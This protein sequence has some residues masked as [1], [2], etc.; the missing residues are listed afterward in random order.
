MGQQQADQGPQDLCDSRQ[1]EIFGLGISARG[2]RQGR[3]R[4]NHFLA[5]PPF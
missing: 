5:M 2:G 1:H 3:V 4:H